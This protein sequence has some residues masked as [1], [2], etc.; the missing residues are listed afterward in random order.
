MGL[1]FLHKRW[2]GAL[3]MALFFMWTFGSAQTTYFQQEVNYKISVR[4]D[5]EQNTLSAKQEIQYINNSPN[6]LGFI[7]FHLW[8]NAYRNNS[9][10]LS[11][12]LLKNGKNTLFFAKEEERGYI[13]SLD[14]KVNGKSIKWEFDP[15]HIDIC[16]LILNQPLHSLDTVKIT[17][18]FFVKIPDAKFSRLGHTGQAFFITQWYPKPAVYDREGWHAMPYLDQ[19]EFYS[20]FGSFDVSITLPEN[21]LL[22]ATG[23]RIDAGAEEDFLDAKVL[24]T[25]KHVAMNTRYDF[26]MSFPKS[27]AK[28]KTVR[29]KQY[30][31]HDFA[32][33]ADKRFYVLRDNIE[34][35]ES[36]RKVD[37]W[38][39]FTDKNFELWKKANSYVNESTRFYSFLNGD[40]PYNQV[41][42]IDGTIMAGGGMEYPNITVI[43]DAGSDFELDLVITH[44]VGHNW[45]YGVL[46]SNERDHP[47]LDEGINSLYEL[48]YI[49]AKYGDRKLT[50]F[51][52]RDSTFTLFGL[53]KYPLWKY[54]EL[55]FFSAMK[56]HTDQALN[57]KSVE[58]TEGNYGS[59]VYS[60]TAIAFDYLLDYMGEENFD[61]A[62]VTYFEN[63]KFKHPAPSDL[64]NV[65]S[66]SS[67][68]DLSWFEKNFYEGTNHIDYKIKRVKKNDDGTYAITIKN[69]SGIK[70]PYTVFAS[71]QNMPVGIGWFK[72]SEKTETISFPA[73][74]SDRFTI[75]RFNRMPDINRNNNSIRTKGLFRKSKPLQLNLLTKLE[76]PTRTQVNYLPI[77]GGN[78]YNGFM[79]GLSVYNYGLYQKRFEYMIAPM[80]A[81]NTNDLA[82]YGEANYNFYSRGFFRQITLGA[83]VKSFSYDHFDT[84]QLN[85]E[86]G[87]SFSDL[88]LRY[89][90][91]SPYIQFDLKK[92][93]PTS[94]ISRSITYANHS[95]FTDSIDDHVVESYAVMGPRKNNEFSFVN[96][97]T[98]KV[99]NGRTIDPYSYNLTLQHTASMA[100]IYGALNYK[101]TLS[102]KHYIDV[103]AF[104]GAFL[105]GNEAEK[106]YYAFRASGYNGWQDYLYEGNY[107]ARN[108]RN[109]IGFNQFMERDGALK[110][111]TP[112]GQ[113]A[114][115]MASINVKSPKIF[116]MPIKVFA[117]AVVCDGR[118]LLND[119]FLWDAGI[120]LTLW[121][122]MIEVYFPLV[123][124]T[125][126]RE[127]LDLNKIEW[128]NRIRFTF[129]IH[130]LDPKR[131]MQ[132]SIF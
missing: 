60:K 71:N 72:G 57:L 23:D 33:F 119:K 65:L 98:Y 116:T 17:T 96:Q 106:G 70:A 55:A 81:F 46:G 67:G 105:A 43:G 14:F 47:F 54:H 29:F 31:V 97:L 62:M 92:K 129:N 108:E 50:T 111:Y 90:R 21:Y 27:S 66:I 6:D 83:K 5:D 82:G 114:E 42:A 74:E 130:K 37:T 32:W 56:A 80:W 122:D 76:D 87:T 7:Y 39:F 15:D 38:V 24:E 51:I 123:Y 117:D 8:P 73:R 41:T 61:K 45:F 110:V 16:K 48:R 79:L 18:P 84:E 22:A 85:K 26:R 59:I 94:L 91:I 132:S 25:K 78:F 69:R 64:F 34:L 75:D 49:R 127:A 124:C 36:K 113:S 53:N 112:L 63:F 88:Y 101:I 52:N 118:A 3:S 40:Y 102:Q 120:N 11:K 121:A 109:G 89:L 107:M 35:P 20:E 103:R 30:R 19:G 9:T 100:K 128:Y 58:Y 1:S 126:I 125:D 86:N 93:D 44:E 115:W 131:V 104:A 12:Q 68:L 2:R 13:D 99:S 28:S 95:I 10:A 4:L 77:A